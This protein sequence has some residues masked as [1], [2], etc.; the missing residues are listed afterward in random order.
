MGMSRISLGKGRGNRREYDRSKEG[1]FRL[2][3]RKWL[4]RVL[5]KHFKSNHSVFTSISQHKSEEEATIVYNEFMKLTPE[6]KSKRIY[7]ND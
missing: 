3:S 4:V 1:V 6:E 7:K 2:H 5:V